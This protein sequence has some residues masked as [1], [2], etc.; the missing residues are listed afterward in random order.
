MRRWP[1]T[2]WVRRLERSAAFDQSYVELQFGR[3]FASRRSA[4][5]HFIRLAVHESPHPLVEGAWIE[6]QAR[7][8]WL[9]ALLRD[10]SLRSSG[11]LFSAAGQGTLLDRLDAFLASPQARSVAAADEY[12]RA[13]AAETRRQQNVAARAA[14]PQW[15]HAAERRWLA[16]LGTAAA[17]PRV[18]VVMPTLNRADVLGRAIASVVAQDYANWQ[19]VVVDDG[20][21]DGT[22]AVLADWCAR[23]ERISSIVL[24][25][26]EGV[27]AARNHGLAAADGEYVAFL[28]SDNE[29]MPGFL[30]HTVT[31][32]GR[33]GALG[34]YTAVELHRDGGVV[35]YLGTPS[36]HS[37][38]LEGPNTVDLN[39][40]VVRRSAIDAVGGFDTALRRWVDYDLVLRLTAHGTLDYLPVLGV[41]YDH[42]ASAADRITTTEGDQWRSVVI[43]KNSLDWHS[44]PARVEGRVSAIVLVDDGWQQALEAVRAVQADEVVVF[45]AGSPRHVTA[46]IGAALLDDPRVR[47]VRVAMPLA[48]ATRANLAF[49]ETT[50][51]QVQVHG[52]GSFDAAA[53]VAAGGFDP[54]AQDLLLRS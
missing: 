9:A 24:A 17:H 35:E 13:H 3:R 33:T 11:P 37:S 46:I 6:Q 26:R 39:A 25:S 1:P 47:L 30:T 34:V 22:A 2:A 21:S 10:R 51:A 29:W 45:D 7:G 52:A 15:D 53:V 14:T 12:L 36:T 19:L 40:L 38:L 31:A 28:D 48:R 27:S 44:L 4:V 49:A 5:R 23:D 18:S 32:L 41:A 54:L 42:R 43:E 8:W 16:D 50:G 20:S